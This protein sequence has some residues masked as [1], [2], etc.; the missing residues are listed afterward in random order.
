MSK[1]DYR[2]TGPIKKTKGFDARRFFVRAATMAGIFLFAGC[3]L[4]VMAPELNGTLTTWGPV[5]AAVGVIE[6]I[7]EEIW[8]IPSYKQ[9][10]V[11]L[12][13]F[14]ITAIILSNL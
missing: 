7:I 3:F 9:R 6:A 11:V 10:A 12:L 13:M 5:F 14:G 2:I 8:D 4:V 1:Y